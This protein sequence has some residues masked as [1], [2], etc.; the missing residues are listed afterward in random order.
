MRLNKIKH[1]IIHK[2]RELILYFYYNNNYSHEWITLHNLN[3]IF[4]KYLD[5]CSKYFIISISLK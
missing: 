5:T 1:K 2:N 4:D 3:V